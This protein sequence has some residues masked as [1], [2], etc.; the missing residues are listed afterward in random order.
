VK[1]ANLDAAVNLDV[2]DG[3]ARMGFYTTSAH[4]A[5]TVT[6]RA[7]QK[8]ML[9]ETVA[10]NPG[11]PLTREVPVPAGIDEHDLVASISDGGRELVSYSPIRLTPPQIPPGVTTPPAPA[12]VKSVEELYLIGLRARQF[13]DPSIDPMPYWEEALRRDPGDSRV[14]TVLG[15]NAYGKARYTE[16]EQYLRKAIAR[17][18]AQFTDPKDVEP[19]YYL[20]AVL[21]AQGKNDEAYT[22]FYKATWGQAWKAAG[23]YELAQ[24]AAARGD[25]TAALD[26]VDRSIDSN[27]MN[28]RA[29]NLKAAL[30]RRTGRSREALQLL[31]TAAHRI[32]PLDVRS[33]AERWLASKDQAAWKALTSAMLNHAQTAQETAAEYLNAGLWEDGTDVLLQM[34][35]AAPDKSKIHPMA[36]YYL[37]YFA[38]RLGRAPKAFEYFKLAAAMPPDYV[39]PFQNEAVEV[40]RA[41][42]KTNP[43]DARAPYYL[44]NLLYDLQPAEAAKLWEASAAIDPAFSI[45]HRNLATAYEHQKPAADLNRAIAELE[46][47]VALEPRC[48]IHFAELDE[49]YEQA[50]VAIEKRLPLFEKN[51]DVVVQR[52]D[53]QNRA[54]ALKVAAGKYDEAIG[55]MT[56]RKFAV[57]EGAN[58]NV[59][60]HWVNAHIL[61]GQQKIAAKLYKEALADLQTA[62]AVPDNLPTRGPAGGG[63]R[64]AE[65]AYLTGLAYEGLGDKERAAESWNRPASPAQ[66]GAGR[67][68]SPGPSGGAQSYYQGL[69]LQ[70]L[71]QADKARANFQNLVESGQLALKEPAETGRGGPGP[72]PRLRSANAH[73]AIG[74]GYLGLG[75]IAKAKAELSQAVEISPDLLG[76][77]VALAGIR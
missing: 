38:E 51:Q 46:K 17:L 4:A 44:G 73:Y 50:G 10:I 70:K 60:E 27:A 24:I 20:G 65:I 72:S 75:E 49:F 74:L 45:V 59:S 61:R 55:M 39:F 48:A 62:V 69:C 7:G 77:R 12:E 21:K 8:V 11:K 14:N 57:A 54:V 23:Y 66:S 76:A 2:A 6:L 9:R 33:S 64:G 19:M 26:L 52:D 15:I 37:G 30:L 16:A 5:A 25:L 67:R 22:Y 63:A 18:T 28:I 47:A 1:K 41:A 34:T 35:A 43:G 42:M 29:Q 13:H 32:D 68:A 40:L 31:A 36:Y 58:L 3:K 56:G 71:G 53:A